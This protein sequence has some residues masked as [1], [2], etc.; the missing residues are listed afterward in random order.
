M[1]KVGLK[2]FMHKFIILLVGLALL[3]C[4]AFGGELEEEEEDETPLCQAV[5]SENSEDFKN[6]GNKGFFDQLF[7]NQ[8]V[9]LFL[10]NL[11]AA[12]YDGKNV[13]ELI[14]ARVDFDFEAGSVDPG[15]F[16][17]F[18]ARWKIIIVPFDPGLLA[19]F[20][21]ATDQIDLDLL[22][23]LFRAQANRVETQLPGPFKEN[24]CEWGD[25]DELG[26]QTL[27]YNNYGIYDWDFYPGVTRVLG[28]VYEG[29]DEIHDDFISF[30]D[31][32]TTSGIVTFEESSLY[33]LQF[34]A[35]TDVLTSQ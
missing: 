12:S 23:N 30:L 32:S 8:S 13:I 7:N 33:K 29:D 5:D 20:V 25:S 15:D 26:T 10:S 28:V 18:Y 4:S 21:A 2:T 9:F 16:G 24:G 19:A 22:I 14:F 1:G 11:V 34:D 27:N 17:G 3:G 31:I 35:F 6:K